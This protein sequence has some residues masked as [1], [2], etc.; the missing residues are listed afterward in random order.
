MIIS[1]HDLTFSDDHS[2][3]RMMPRFTTNHYMDHPQEPDHDDLFSVAAVPFEKRGHT[4]TL[5]RSADL[6]LKNSWIVLKEEPP[7]NQKRFCALPFLFGIAF[8]AQQMS[9]KPT[10]EFLDDHYVDGAAWDQSEPLAPGEI[11][12]LVWD[13][14]QKVFLAI[15][16]DNLNPEKP[17]IERGFGRYYKLSL[18][19]DESD[20]GKF[21]IQLTQQVKF[22]YFRDSKGNPQGVGQIDGEG[23]ALLRSGNIA[24]ASEGHGLIAE[25]LS[26][27]VIPLAMPSLTEY[28]PDGEFV[29]SYAVP[30]Y[31]MPVYEGNRA[32][33]GIVHNNSFEGL[34][35]IGNHLFAATES[36]LLQDGGAVGFKKSGSG[37]ML[38]YIKRT[39]PFSSLFG[40]RG[41]SATFELDGEFAY[42]MDAIPSPS[43]W[44]QWNEEK[45]GENGVAEILALG[46]N[47]LLVL[48]RAYVIQPYN[49]NHIRLY[50]V[51]LV[52]ASNILGQETLGASI[53][54]CRK[55]LVLDLDSI[56][57]YL[58]PDHLRKSTTGSLE[59]YEGMALYPL[60]DKTM[61]LVMI[62]DDNYRRNQQRF[63]LLLFRIHGLDDT[64]SEML[65][66]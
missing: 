24:V 42:P 35:R 56:L 52:G 53:I 4:F 26:G 44:G 47:R 36:P 30:D 61:G 60:P 17:T 66:D 50:D 15:S 54:P 31:Y 41:P 37:R 13:A 64:V 57:P 1:K 25:T 58:E 8:I 22:V 16:D 7:V 5:R 27:Q 14:S 32:V 11:S 6:P 39:Q 21:A 43:S 40:L 45:K 18:A 62:A 2:K 59:N 48:E 38:R 3:Q 20:H 28:T 65:G 33:K 10:L 34:S 49:R 29:Q 9:A 51:T 55:E 46:V 23:I 63:S 12:G 19:I